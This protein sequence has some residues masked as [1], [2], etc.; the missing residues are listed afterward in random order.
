MS[1]SDANVDVGVLEVLRRSCQITVLD[2]PVGPLSDLGMDSGGDD[3]AAVLDGT[4]GMIDGSSS[5][6]SSMHDLSMSHRV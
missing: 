4:G 1:F 5:E 6:P 2:T 3:R